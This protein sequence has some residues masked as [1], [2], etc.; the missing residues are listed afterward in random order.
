[1]TQQIPLSPEDTARLERIISQLNRVLDA[2]DRFVSTS[3]DAPLAGSP[4]KAAYQANLRDPYQQAYLLLVAAADHLRTI[5]DLVKQ[6]RLPQFALYTLLRSAGEAAVRARHLLDPMLDERQRLAR[7]L[8]ERLDNIEEARK[9]ETSEPFDYDAKIDHLEERA[10]ANDIMPLRKSAISPITA[11]GEPRKNVIDLFGLYLPAGSLAF[12][13]LCG[14]THSMMW[15]LIQRERAQP[16]S[17]PTVARVPTDLNVPLFTTVL[18]TV[19]RLHDKNCG[20]LLQLG[21]YPADVWNM[22]KKPIQRDAT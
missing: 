17:D 6:G 8:N 1:M 22:A 5:V 7:G 12:R 21:G 10:S 14:F 2:S 16:T 13:F 20:Y 3:I 19:V 4:M 9:V 11:F 18:A 15:T